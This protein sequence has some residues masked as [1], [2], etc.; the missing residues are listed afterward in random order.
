MFDYEDISKGRA[1]ENDKT[2]ILNNKNIMGKMISR[3]DAATGKTTAMT[4]KMNEWATRLYNECN[5][6]TISNLALGLSPKGSTSSSDTST[7]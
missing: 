4:A 5:G 7:V 2:K 1:K 3:P 6:F